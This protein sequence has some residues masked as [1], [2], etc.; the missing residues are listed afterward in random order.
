MAK[1]STAASGECNCLAPRQ[2]ARHI[3]Q[4]RPAPTGLR[5][6]QYGILA[7]L[8]RHGPM[9][10]QALAAERVM[11]RTS[12]GRDVR[13]LERDGLIVIEAEIDAAGSCVSPAPD[14]DLSAPTK[15]GLRRRSAS[16]TRTD[17]RQVPRLLPSLRAVIASGLGP[18]DSVG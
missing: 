6:T 10:I 14:V 7:K 18:T 8:K 15:D 4:Q 2:A 12:L 1:V 5:T 3:T 11:D 13:P 17:T 9:S 16:R